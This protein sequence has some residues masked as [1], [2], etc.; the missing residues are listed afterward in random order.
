MLWPFL[1]NGY[2]AL[3]SQLPALEDR[4]EATCFQ[5]LQ[6]PEIWG[7]A[8]AR[9]TPDT[10]LSIA[11]RPLGQQLQLG[12]LRAGGSQPPREARAPGR[13]I[14]GEQRPLLHTKA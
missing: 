2:G 6:G 10:P 13:S 9:H 14:Y 5:G 7:S 11:A 12:A 4:Y 1:L 3:G 8:N